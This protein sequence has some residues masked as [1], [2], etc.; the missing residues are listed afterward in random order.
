MNTDD[1]NLTIEQLLAEPE[2][3]P[4]ALHEQATELTRRK[5]LLAAT[6]CFATKGYQ[7][8]TIREIAA[9]AGMTLGAVY[10]HFESKKE[11]LM[12]LNRS[13]QIRSLEIFRTSM[14]EKEDFFEGLRAGLRGQFRFLAENKILR[15][16]TR[17]YLGMAMVDPD[18]NRMHGKNDIEFMEIAEKELLRRYPALS[19]EKRS[20]LIRMLFVTFEGLM[21]ALAVDSPMAV[22][23][24][25]IVDGLLDT[26]RYAMERWK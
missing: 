15:G 1:S 5:I 7:K 12:I 20:S 16:V 4:K 10:H 3:D 22:K 6:E 21:T 13:R 23:P 25:E 18:I 2:A 14:A 8:T 9:E 26:F 17:E 24:E 19:A 11:L